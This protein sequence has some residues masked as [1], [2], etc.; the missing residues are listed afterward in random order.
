MRPLFGAIMLYGAYIN[1]WTFV[2]VSV[3]GL[4]T[5]WF[6]FPKPKKV[7]PWIE[8]FIEVEYEYVTPPWSAKKILMLLYVLVGLS[9]IVA[10]FWYHSA[11]IGL[12]LFIVGSLHKA[13]W[14]YNVSKKVGDPKVGIPAA[15]IGVFSA[16]VAAIILYLI[17]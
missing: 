3:F 15:V 1:S 9:A 8:K 2:A 16:A 6:W 12:V 11:K 17:S 7:Y 10:A 13:W 5:S 14:S 4:T